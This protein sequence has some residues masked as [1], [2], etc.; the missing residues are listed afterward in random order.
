MTQQIVQQHVVSH[1]SKL[2]ALAMQGNVV[3]GSRFNGSLTEPVLVGGLTA[4]D[5]LQPAPVSD[6]Q[7]TTMTHALMQPAN[8]PNVMGPSTSASGPTT[9]LDK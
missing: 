3:I 4:N 6:G 8:P 9:E 5:D 1:D 2:G 7:V